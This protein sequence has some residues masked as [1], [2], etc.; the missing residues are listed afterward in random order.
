MFWE[1]FDERQR[2]RLYETLRRFE[3]VVP[4]PD[5]DLQEIERMYN[6]ILWGTLIIW[7]AF[8]AWI[9]MN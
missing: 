9:T 4:V 2:G 7:L 5:H 1:R 3:N 8:L 6:S